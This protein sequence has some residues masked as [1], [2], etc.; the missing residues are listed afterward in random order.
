MKKILLLILLLSL[1][2]RIS[3][4]ENTI[5]NYE[6]EPAIDLQTTLLN[7][8]E[9]SNKGQTFSVYDT[10]HQRISISTA[11]FPHY[12]VG[13]VLRITGRVEVKKMSGNNVVFISRNPQIVLVAANM[14]S[15]FAFA[16]D[17]RQRTKLL[18]ETSLP[19]VAS[20]LLMGI[21]F[22]SKEQFPDDFFDNL[23]SAGVLH[24]IAASGMNVAFVAAAVLS[25][26]M[27]V[28]RRQYALLW[29]GVAVLCYVLM[30]GYQPSILR[31]ALMAI[32]ALG[33][34]ALGRQHFAIW[35]LFVSA[36]ILLF[37]EPGFLHDIGFALSFL[38]TLGI[39]CLKPLFPLKQTIITETVT[40]TLA[41]Q[42]ATFPVLV[43]IIGK[44]G[45]FSLCANVTILWAVPFL[46][47]LGSVAALLNLFVPLLA[48]YSLYLSLP[49]L[50]FMENAI[51]FFGT[52]GGVITLP[53]IPWQFYGAYYLFLT[54]IVVKR[55]SY[56][57]KQNLEE[58]LRWE[59][60]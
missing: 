51:R 55:K 50:L 17:F 58:S 6:K 36:Y 34:N 9:L 30:V 45:L 59:Q 26:S 1:V 14:N 40:T 52:L 56:A 15:F 46:M 8:P 19:P 32:M 38:A 49:F 35:A 23:Q 39:I 41:A 29:G 57:I 12:Q 11:A 54:A 18:Y 16:N 60:H 47:L 27:M 20:S 48:S 22:G 44:F 21:V 10:S 28:M 24:I 31:A 42:I 7:V 25:V 13:N 3:N 4:Y 53:H 2:Y 37:F 5:P 43:G 33:A